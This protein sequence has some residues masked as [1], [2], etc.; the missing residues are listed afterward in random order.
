MPAQH[1]EKVDEEA[2]GLDQKIQGK[3]RLLCSDPC[4]LDSTTRMD[5]AQDPT[6]KGR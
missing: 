4:P 6:A 2:L 3:R 5:V 1:T